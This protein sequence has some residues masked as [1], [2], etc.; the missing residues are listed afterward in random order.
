MS[1][2][3]YRKKIDAI[4]HQLL[5]LLAERLEISKEI[6]DHKLKN[7]LPILDQEREMNLFQERIKA[8]QELGFYDETFIKGLF[9][10]IIK[11]SRDL[12][13]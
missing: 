6:S 10:M 5:K 3:G 11:K 9:E 8:F 4:D 12:Q 1:L 13:Q 2:Q 7:N